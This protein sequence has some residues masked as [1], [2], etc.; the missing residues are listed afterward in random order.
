MGPFVRLAALLGLF[1][2][3][4]TTA[5]AAEPTVEVFGL[6]TMPLT[7][8]GDARVYYLDTVRLLE[9]SLSAGLPTDPVRA[10]A[11][12]AQRMAALGPALRQRAED[13][14]TGLARAAQ[15][16]VNRAP[17]IVFD[18]Q[19][20]VYGLTDVAAARRVFAARVKR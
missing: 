18:G 4:A 6:S 9:Q 15:L 16:G 19:W 20:V 11:V 14:G 3:I 7:N 12:A 8:L 1:L 13:G 17:A 10:Q 2:G 5:S